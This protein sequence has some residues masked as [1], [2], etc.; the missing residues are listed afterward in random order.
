MPELAWY[1]S[2]LG[3]TPDCEACLRQLLSEFFAAAVHSVAI[4]RHTTPAAAAQQ[5]INNYHERGHRA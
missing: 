1:D 2:E 3:P 4:S 5:A